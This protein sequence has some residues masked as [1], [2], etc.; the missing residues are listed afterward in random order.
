MANEHHQFE[1]HY[2]PA[3]FWVITASILVLG[4]VL[5]RPFLPAITWAIVL[6]VLTYPLYERLRK[7]GMGE[8]VAAT[9]TL[10]GT[11]FAIAI[12]LLLIGLMMFTQFSDTVAQIQDSVRTTAAT[13]GKSSDA[14]VHEIARFV[15]PLTKQLG[16]RID[17]PN[18]YMANKPQISQQLGSAVAQGAQTL[19]YG[20]F[21][22]I[23]ALLTM[24]FMI[25][26]GHRLRG[27]A[28][29]LLPI[30]AERSGEILDR[31]AETIRAV[32]VG[33]VL[34]A[35]VQAS[36]AFIAYWLCGVPSPALFAMATF[37]S[38]VIPLLGGPI[39]YGPLSL[40]LILQGET[41]KGV[42]LLLVGVIIVSQVDNLLRPFVIGARVQLHPMAV[43]FGLLG[44]V[45]AF[46]PVGIM[47]GP[48][49]LTAMIGLQDMIRMSRRHAGEDQGPST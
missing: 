25:R 29:E 39:V 37:I 32:F 30:P 4:T 34:V 12:P 13:G 28:L 36:I 31:M 48:V 42:I 33:V 45:L 16:L 7:R 20:A 19:G 24:F 22:M 10:F 3:A 43:F 2:R 8:N 14:V 27:P 23:V 17:I 9:I 21:T 11:I 6:S 15:D 38:C 41:A 49:V 47:A 40:S 5:F 1:R 18:W 44:G 35:M 26:D 46:G